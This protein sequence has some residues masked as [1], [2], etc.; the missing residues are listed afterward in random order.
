MN[1]LLAEAGETY[2][3]QRDQSDFA[4]K[5]QSSAKHETTLTS[6]DWL[7]MELQQGASSLLTDN[8]MVVTHQK[9]CS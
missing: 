7:A 3:T 4:M 1:R 6:A 9:Q 5:L 2:S 8:H